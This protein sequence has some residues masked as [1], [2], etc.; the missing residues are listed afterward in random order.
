MNSDELTAAVRDGA[1]RLLVQELGGSGAEESYDRIVSVAEK[2]GIC[3]HEL[4][5]DIVMLLY[6]RILFAA[7]PA[8]QR[9][10]NFLERQRVIRAHL[11]DRV[12]R[13][14]IDGLSNKLVE[15]LA[16]VWAGLDDGGLGLRDS[17][18]TYD[19]YA[20]AEML[21]RQG[22]RCAVCGVPVVENEALTDPHFE[23]GIEPVAAKALEHTL[24]FYLFGN[25]GAYEILCEGC[26]GCKH[27]RLG[28]Q[29]DGKVVSGNCVLAAKEP[30]VRRRLH[31]WTLYRKRKC[32]TAGC[33]QSARTSVLYVDERNRRPDLFGALAAACKIHASAECRWLHHGYVSSP[34][35][36]E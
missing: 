5:H 8:A 16:Y 31:F 11:R 30:R 19:T 17:V 24:P 21:Q 36:D 27:D 22:N 15:T 32:D 35:E 25:K 12:L 34:A 33:D 18:S 13:Y 26:N 7:I 2:L 14:G 4:R 29:E 23:D 28:V 9:C 6:Q 1:P 10:T 3:G 20:L